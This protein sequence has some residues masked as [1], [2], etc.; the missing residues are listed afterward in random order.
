MGVLVDSALCSAAARVSYAIMEERTI[1]SFQY[2]SAWGVPLRVYRFAR[3]YSG[4]WR[5]GSL[6]VTIRDLLPLQWFLMRENKKWIPN[7]V[8][9]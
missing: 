1:S 9:N 2:V 5:K 4:S 8:A 3:K 6:D 7:V